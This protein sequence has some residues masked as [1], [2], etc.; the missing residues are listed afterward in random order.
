MSAMVHINLLG[1]SVFAAGAALVLLLSFRETLRDLG[2]IFPRRLLRFR[3]RTLLLGA[4]TLQVALALGFTAGGGDAYRG[5]SSALAMLLL[6]ILGYAG[7]CLFGFFVEDIAGG[8]HTAA[9]K[10]QAIAS[11]SRRAASEPPGSPEQGEAE[12]ESVITRSARVSR[13]R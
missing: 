3:L 13:P 12:R 10:Y 4:F 11:M 6:S 5:C 1:G 9:R 8:A 7:F 2:R